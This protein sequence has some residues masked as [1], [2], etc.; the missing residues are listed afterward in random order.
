MTKKNQEKSC[1]ASGKTRKPKESLVERAK[2]QGQELVDLGST[3]VNTPR[4]LPSHVGGLLRRSL[5]KM[6]SAR[7]GGFY[8]S[9]FVI[10]FVFLEISTLFA[11]L[12]SS[13][14]VGG[15]F[16]EQIFHLVFRFTIESFGNTLRSLLWPLLL[17]NWSPVFGGI[18]L[19]MGYLV[20]NQYIK[21]PL[22]GLLFGDQ[23]VAEDE[24]TG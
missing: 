11:E 12:Q 7:G 15:F 3:A 16:G 5:F 9:G 6:Y 1:Q 18:F 14:G 22:E 20:F 10:C 23:Q 8:A 4:Q 13:G 17:I 21:K 24:S 19:L 2:K